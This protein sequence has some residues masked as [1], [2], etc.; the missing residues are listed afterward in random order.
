MLLCSV[1]L[2]F[3]VVRLLLLSMVVKLFVL[4]KEMEL[5]RG[6]LWLV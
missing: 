3:F 6:L 5:D 4:M 1:V 2:K